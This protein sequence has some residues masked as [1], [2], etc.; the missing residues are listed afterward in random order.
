MSSLLMALSP[1]LVYYSRYYIHEMLL[2]LFNVG[3]I[4]TL[5]RYSRSGKPGWIL[6]AGIFAG[7]MFST[8]ETWIILVGSQF[9]AF[10]YCKL[11]Y[12]RSISFIK[13]KWNFTGFAHLS[14]FILPAAAV[15]VLLFSS[16]FQN[17]GGIA[18]SV[19][20]YSNYF[21]RASGEAVHVHPWY[22]YFKAVFF[23]SCNT[24]FFQGRFMAVCSR[25]FRDG[26]CIFSTT[27]K[28]ETGLLFCLLPSLLF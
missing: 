4:I 10:P 22:Y 9:V 7:L 1:A 28:S 16:F 26:S 23:D 19:I 6:L 14:L 15:A 20:T 24:L 11:P 2:I 27:G 3:L 13:K 21:N 25:F 18:D 5:F 12:I 17:P 8:K